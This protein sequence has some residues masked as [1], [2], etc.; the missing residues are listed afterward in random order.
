MM[1]NNNEKFE[2]LWELNN[3]PIFCG[4]TDLRDYKR[5]DLIF[6]IDKS[7]GYL[8]ILNNVDA[9]LLYEYSHNDAIGEAWNLHN[10]AFAEFI[11]HYIQHKNVLE[12]GAG[13]GR[14]FKMVKD[15]VKSWTMLDFNPLLKTG[16]YENLNVKSCDASKFSDFRNIDVI[17]HSHFI[18]HLNEPFD[19]IKNLQNAK[20]GTYICCSIPNQIEMLKS[21][22]TSSINFEHCSILNEHLVEYT[23]AKFGY[24]LV[25]KQMYGTHSIFYTF[26][27][28]DEQIPFENFN[29]YEYN[30]NIFLNYK[31]DL[32]DRVKKA[33]EYIKDRTYNMFFAHL[34]SQF[35]FELGLDYSKCENILDNS[36]M[37]QNK[38]LYGYEL[39]IINP[40][41][42]N[43]NLPTLLPKS[44]YN[45][46]I[47]NQLNMLGFT[48]VTE[49]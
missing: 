41:N 27:R 17:T 2:I 40:K 47:I 48:D 6:V 4:Q 26:K 44:I 24:K 21:G 7:T 37:K 15:D 16:E 23:H 5:E 38:F 46:E 49:I 1:L 30:K 25:K 39:K 35:M 42:A 32:V 14:I 43:K 9:S 3:F 34:F 29:M 22:Y 45:T 8:K 31:N 20:I 36:P 13:S 10:A 11:K 33:K 18:E 12:L 19:F 28:T